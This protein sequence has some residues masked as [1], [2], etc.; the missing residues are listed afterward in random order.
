MPRMPDFNLLPLTHMKR[1]P[2]A[3]WYWVRAHQIIPGQ[4]MSFYFLFFL[5]VGIV[6]S[7]FTA[8]V[9]THLT[10]LCLGNLRCFGQTVL[11]VQFKSFWLELLLIHS[12]PV[13]TAPTSFT[14]IKDG[15]WSSSLSSFSTF[16]IWSSSFFFL[17]CLYPIASSILNL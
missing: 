11:S 17:F 1:L 5:S 15:Y 4:G 10:D 8:C 16:S 14:E 3:T 7:I 6:R 9:E 13:F 2:L 12:H